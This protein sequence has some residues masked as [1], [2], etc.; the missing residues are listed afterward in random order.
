[1]FAV[2]VAALALGALPSGARAAAC[3]GADACPWT[4]IDTFGDVGGGEFR[5]PLG[6]AADAG[7]NL[8]VI[9]NDTYRVQKLDPTGGYV[10]EW[11]RF[12]TAE[13]EFKWPEDIAVDART[14]RSTSPT[15]TTIGSR[16]ST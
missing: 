4:Q 7:G 2:L 13:G 5:A 6:V 8:Y 3:P 10:S 15:P 1:M 16:S 11:G 12:G 9:E 14:A